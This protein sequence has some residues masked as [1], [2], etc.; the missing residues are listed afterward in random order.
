MNNKRVFNGHDYNLPKIG[1][2]TINRIST[3]KTY[4]EK[5]NYLLSDG[6]L[7]KDIAIINNIEGNTVWA[8]CVIGNKNYNVAHFL[9]MKEGW[10][11]YYALDEA[12]YES[13]FN[14]FTK[15]K[16]LDIQTSD[17]TDMSH[18]TEYVLRANYNKDDY[19]LEYIEGTFYNSVDR[20]KMVIRLKEFMKNDIK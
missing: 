17:D 1:Y 12:L 20:D 3:D 19:Y 2:A 10:K 7:D 13:W 16:I 18:I 14:K 15:Y 6:V 11:A 4:E 5:V 8:V 9:D